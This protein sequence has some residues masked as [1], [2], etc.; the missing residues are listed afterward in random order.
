[1]STRGDFKAARNSCGC[2]GLIWFLG[3]SVVLAPAMATNNGFGIAV[4]A[5]LGIAWTV[6]ALW[7]VSKLG[8]PSFH[9]KTRWERQEATR[10]RKK[11][12]KEGS[13]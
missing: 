9:E 3:L 11:A 13:R 10:L 1:M 6:G 4:G 12:W 8:S 2:I 7:L 5:I